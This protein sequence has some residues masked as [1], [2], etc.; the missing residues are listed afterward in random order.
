MMSPTTTSRFQSRQPWIASRTRRSINNVVKSDKLSRGLAAPKFECL[1]TISLAPIEAASLSLVATRPGSGSVPPRC[2]GNRAP[3]S[4]TG[5]EPEKGGR[6]KKSE[7]KK[8]QQ[9][10]RFSH[11]R[12]DSARAGRTGPRQKGK[13]GRNFWI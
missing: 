2:R 6:G 11:E 13:S 3:S 12:L 7:A 4:T 9:T 1:G 10:C 5:Q 8:A